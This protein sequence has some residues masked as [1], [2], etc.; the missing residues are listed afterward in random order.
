MKA[1]LVSVWT[2]SRAKTITKEKR[3]FMI[4]Q[5]EREREEGKEELEGLSDLVRISMVLV[6]GGWWLASEQQK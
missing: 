3:S 2:R 5:R 6:V 1:E 4:E